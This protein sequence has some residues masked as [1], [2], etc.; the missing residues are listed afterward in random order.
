MKEERARIAVMVV[1]FHLPGCRSL[2][3]K[4]KR[5]AR[6]RDKFGSKPQVA[7]CEAGFADVL[8]SSRWTFVVAAADS[9]VVTQTLAQ[10]ENYLRTSIDAQIVHLHTTNLESPEPAASFT[11]MGLNDS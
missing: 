3:E 4:R 6:L 9:T 10:I 2:K 5:L 7:V 8:Q 11:N 1:D